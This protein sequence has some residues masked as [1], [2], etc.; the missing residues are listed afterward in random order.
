[1]SRSDGQLQR[2]ICPS[3]FWASKIIQH[4]HGL[5]ELSK[6]QAPDYLSLVIPPH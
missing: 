3:V 5:L 1:M 6:R 4:Y 2:W